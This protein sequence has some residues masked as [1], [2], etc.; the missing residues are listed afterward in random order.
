MSA[1]DVR[2]DQL[3]AVVALD[4]KYRS[5][6]EQCRYRNSRTPTVTGSKQDLMNNATKK[7]Q[8]W[9]PRIVWKIWKTLSGI[10]KGPSGCC[11]RFCHH[12]LEQPTLYV[13]SVC[14]VG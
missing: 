9:N 7:S 2:L 14:N 11:V 1:A 5:S 3:P 12:R 10:G 13:I 4:P 6:A 8:T